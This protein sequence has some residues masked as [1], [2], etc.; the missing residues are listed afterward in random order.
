M[1]DV[2]S[3][4]VLTAVL[5][6]LLGNPQFIL[7]RFFPNTQSEPS[8]QIHFD[9]IQGKRRV[10]PFVSPLVEGQVV[11][12]QGFNTNTFTPAYIKD[13]RV[14]DMN[15]P[16]K[17]SPGEQI[18]GT[19]S[20][21]DRQRYLIAFDMQD[22]LAMM[23]RRLEVMAG[24]VLA[25]GKSTITGDKY[26]TQVVDFGRLNTHTFDISGSTPWTTTGSGPLDNLQDWAQIVLEDVGVF[27]NDVLMDVTTWKIFRAN[28][29]I[30]QRL[31]IYRTIGALPTMAMAAQVEEGGVFMGTVDGFNIFVYSGWYI[32]P[33]DGTQKSILPAKTVI[34]ASPAMM[35]VQAFGAIRDEEVGLQATP[36]FVKSWIQFDPSVRYIMLQSAPLIVPFRPDAS[37]AVKVLV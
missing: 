20:P 2:F 30:Q 8:E 1:A 21:A 18:G 27:P 37:L 25:T 13:K 3:T 5:Q 26:P 32:D 31:N 10:A 36:Y 24:E 19:M 6:S 28:D 4:D 29:V 7:D 23:R 33:A 12:S 34:M 16:L 35:G 15:R 11:A 14:F 17:R 22:Q 9:V